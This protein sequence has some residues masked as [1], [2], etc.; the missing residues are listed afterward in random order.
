MWYHNW[1]YPRCHVSEARWTMQIFFL[2]GCPRTKILPEQSNSRS[3][4]SK[5]KCSNRLSPHQDVCHNW[6]CPGGSVRKPL[7][8]MQYSFLWGGSCWEG[9]VGKGLG[10]VIYQKRFFWE[11][12]RQINAEKFFTLMRR[13][14]LLNAKKGVTQCTDFRYINAQKIVT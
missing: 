6:N 8:N 4:K 7:W 1:R 9:V 11:K 3:W 2:G 12:F 10:S 13:N 5:T 14:S